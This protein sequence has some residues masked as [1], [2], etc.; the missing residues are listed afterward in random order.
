MV[1]SHT[2]GLPNELIGDDRLALAFD[3][4][5]QF[6]YSGEG[7]LM[8]QRVLE[9]MTG[10]SL[11]A[12]ARALVTGP[13][14]MTRSGFVWRNE[15]D[16]N[17]AVGHDGERV[18]RRPSRPT[19]ARASSG[20]QTTVHD[21]SRFVRALLRREGLQPATFDQMLAPRVRAGES[22]DW[23]LG[24]ALESSATGRAAFHWGDNS[25]SGFTA[26]AWADPVQGRGVVYFANSTSGL[27]LVRPA[28]AL[29]GGEH[30]APAFMGY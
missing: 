22:V 14:G 25:N 24:W 15:F 27:R 4:G 10:E 1:L 12:L 11:D 9:W 3:P 5:R 13:L 17:A 2:T 7:Y 18:P 28:L 21:Y 20:F 6:R 30:P 16:D 19:R 26:F 23:G 8:L 29:I